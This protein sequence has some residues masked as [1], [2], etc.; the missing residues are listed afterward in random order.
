MELD[1]VHAFKAFAPKTQKVVTW[2]RS[3]EGLLFPVKFVRQ[4]IDVDITWV[5]KI[6]ADVVV[7]I[8]DRPIANVRS[9]YDNRAFLD[10]LTDEF[11]RNTA[12]STVKAFNLSIE[13]EVDVSIRAWIEDIPTFGPAPDRSGHPT[14]LYYALSN[15]QQPV[16]PWYEGID[17]A[18]ARNHDVPLLTDRHSLMKIWSSRW[19]DSECEA[20]RTRF[21]LRAGEEVRTAGEP[22]YLDDM[23]D[24]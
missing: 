11:L 20:A 3:N 9:S 19:S 17:L 13:S 14:P 16:I 4:V 7:G 24:I 8:G 15:L 18:N 23:I 2:V 5:R 21:E 6:H 22:A 10:V 12:R 1:Y